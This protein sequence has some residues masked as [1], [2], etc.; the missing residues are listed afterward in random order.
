MTV[1]NALAANWKAQ[2][3]RDKQ[4]WQEH[5]AA[6]AQALAEEAANFEVERMDVKQ[7]LK[8]EMKKNK[9][10]F[11]SIPDRP[12]PMGALV[13][14]APYAVHHLERGHYV[15]LYYYTN[16]GLLAAAAAATQD[17]DYLALKENGDSTAGEVPVAS[18]RSVERVIPDS[19]LTWGQLREAVPRFIP[20]MQQA[21]WAGERLKKF[22]G[23]LEAH[24]FQQSIDPID[25][26]TLVVYQ[27][28]QRL[29][30]HQAINSTDGAW[31]LHLLSEEILKETRGRVYRKDQ[32]AK[33]ATIDEAA[34]SSPASL[35]MTRH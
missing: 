30:W 1:I 35:A 6:E 16:R 25:T 8:D 15:E 21:R 27:A 33:D 9:E 22:W 2:N 17:Q 14:A 28:E 13:M 31:N 11:V 7:A 26:R 3:E 29:R 34:V 20:A 5:T 4:A 12:T 32:M 23:N 19:E 18:L 10:K 24:P